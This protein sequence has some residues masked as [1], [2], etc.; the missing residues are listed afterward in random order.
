MVF[1]MFV[2]AKDVYL[3]GEYRLIG[4]EAYAANASAVRAL[5]CV[6][7]LGVGSLHVFSTGLG[8]CVY[9]ED[10]VLRYDKSDGCLLSG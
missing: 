10:M 3:G 7:A 2:R 4:R 9:L 8:Y 5:F 6:S 1:D